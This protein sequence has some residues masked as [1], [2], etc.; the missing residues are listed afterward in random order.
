[1]S[2]AATAAGEFIVGIDLGTTNSLIARFTPAGPEVIRDESGDPLV[3]SVV[4]LANGRVVVG[5]EARSLAV[6]HPRST[7]YSIKRLMGRGMADLSD[8]ERR[9]LPYEVVADERQ[10]AK[11][12]V[13]DRVMGPEELSALILREL[14]TRAERVLARPVS[15]AVITVPAYFDDAQ[16]QATRVAGKLAGL[17]V[18]RIVNEPTAAALAYGLDRTKS[19]CVAVYDLGGGTFDVSVLE[20]R[21]GIFRVRSTAG[22]TQLGGDDFDRKLMQ[23]LLAR[24]P[25]GE[26]AD[27]SLLQAAKLAAEQAKIELSERDAV[28]WAVVDERDDRRLEDT[29]TRVEFEALIAPEVERTLQCCRRALADAD[30]SNA[31]LRAVVLV[32]GSTRVPVVR[33]RVAEFFGRKPYTG[34]DPDLVVALGAAVQADVL[35]GGARDLLLLDVI[36]LSLGLETFG[37]AAAKIVMRNTPIP[38]Q[39]SDTFTTHV[40][41]QTAID[42]HVVQGERELVK[43]CRSLG[44]FKLRGLPPLAAGMVRVDVRFLIDENGVLTV[45]AK[46]RFT[47]IEASIEVVPSYGL[48]DDEVARMVDESFR[49]ARQDFEAHQRIDLENECR[50][51]LDSTA[52]VL[53]DGAHG[54]D[55]AAVA[56]I[57][58]AAAQVRAALPAAPVKELKAAYDRFVAATVPLA[59]VVMSEVAQRVVAGRTVEEVLAAP[60]ATA[61]PQEA[62]TFAAAATASASAPA[63]EGGRKVVTIRR[64][65]P[66]S[67]PDVKSDAKKECGDLGEGFRA[68]PAARKEATAMKLDWNDAEEIGLRLCEKLRGVEPLTVRF[69]DLHRHVCALEGFGGDPKLSNEKVL[70]AIQMAWLE[71]YN[72]AR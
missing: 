18:V 12:K 69:T 4:T 23:R 1:M 53:A 56:E 58:A 54:L 42:L 32:G 37:G 44:R 50:T 67:G 49:Y 24:L 7:V 51:M 62:T 52:K 13:G 17:E 47:S 40:A 61:R 55:A 10:L 59:G 66:A 31:D 45:H 28:T 25:A 19:G 65:A 64:G 41:N 60:A 70:E 57:D 35:S 71:E 11:V 5:R 8:A 27:P 21:D 26:A 48:T 33:R 36:P 72:D 15:K 63:L 43:D 16:R 2:G 30:L 68:A 38:A 22:D 6:D 29:I 3:P 46:E 14:K 39:A 34:L 9:S 20:I